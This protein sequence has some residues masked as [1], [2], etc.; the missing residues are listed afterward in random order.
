MSKEQSTNW[1]DQ[2]YRCCRE[3]EASQIAEF[4]ISLP[5]LAAVVIG[6]T[7][8][9]SAFDL[10]YK[11]SNAV[12]EGARVGSMQSTS[13]ITNATPVSVTAVRDEIDSYLTGDHVND[14]GLATAVPAQ[15]GL[16]WT[17]TAS[18]GCPGGG[19][20]TLTVD[21]GKTFQTTGG[22]TVETT[23]VSISY[24]FQW[25]FSKVIRVL[26]PGAV[27]QGLSYISNEAAMQN[28]N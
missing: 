2:V 20:L 28:L 21:R 12:R 4:A 16:V 22:V 27:Y 6:I 8:F 5:L 18:S 7:D 17:Y 13:D 9:G 1:I 26:V 23:R 25:R 24:P 15:S 3:A 11:L 19:T 14:C 10:K